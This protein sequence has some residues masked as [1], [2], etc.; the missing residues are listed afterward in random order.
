MSRIGIMGV[1][2][3]RYVEELIDIWNN[4]A[5]AVLIDS[6]TPLSALLRIL[7]E[8]DVKTCMVQEEYSHFFLMTTKYRRRK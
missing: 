1:N 6:G 7:E 4:G 3:V 2:S 5:C 8:A